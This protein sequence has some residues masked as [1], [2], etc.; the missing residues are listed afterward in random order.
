MNMKKL[1]LFI[2]I[3]LSIISVGMS[4]SSPLTTYYTYTWKYSVA[5][6][7]G[8]WQN[9]ANWTQTEGAGLLPSAT[10]VVVFQNLSSPAANVSFVITNVPNVTI[11]GLKLIKNGS[12]TLN[13][14]LKG[15]TDATVIHINGENSAND[16]NGDFV[17]NAYCSLNCNFSSGVPIVYQRVNIVLAP[18]AKG[19]FNTGAGTQGAL[20]VP[21]HY[22]T[23]DATTTANIEARRDPGNPSYYL[24]KGFLLECNATKRAELIQETANQSHIHCWVESYMPYK[25]STTGLENYHLICPPTYTDDGVGAAPSVDPIPCCLQKGD[26]LHESNDL[27][28]LG[29]PLQNLGYMVRFWDN[30]GQKWDSWLGAFPNSCDYALDFY[31]GS[32]SYSGG[33]GPNIPAGVYSYKGNGIEVYTLPTTHQAYRDGDLW[34]GPLNTAPTGVAPITFDISHVGFNLI[35]NPFPSAIRCGEPGTGNQTI[36]W[37]WNESNVEQYIYYWD[38]SNYRIWGWSSD[39]TLN[40]PAGVPVN[41]IAAGQ[42]FFVYCDAVPTTSVQFLTLNNEARKFYPNDAGLIV[43]SAEVNMLTFTLSQGENSLMDQAK[44]YFRDNGNVNYCKNLDAYKLFRGNDAVGEL[45]TRTPEGY[46]VAIKTYKASTGSFISPLYFQVGTTGT[47]K[48]TASDLSTFSTRTAIQL[49]DKK[50]NKTIDLKVNPEYSFTATN[51]DDP[52]RFDILFTDVLNGVVKNSDSPVKVYT[53]HSSIFIVNSTNNELQNANVTVCDMLGREVMQDKLF[54]AAGEVA[55][56]NANLNHGYYII[57]VR[58]SS[59]VYTQ[60]VYIE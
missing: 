56:L 37:Q 6:T 55:E 43:K 38:G 39:Y 3:M 7:G 42:G 25:T 22:I 10:S 13:V 32:L 51:G 31:V 33:V 46:D 16:A 57:S 29:A 21:A 48:L 11:D 19:M 17:I 50:E 35:G 45:Y 9:P 14:T 23:C 36:G 53:S 20:F 40:F 28:E 34:Y 59:N 12:K 2:V 60:K 47:Y 58:T 27:N 24:N 54:L 52:Y 1:L 44:I 4:Q 30:V 15:A 5:P 8:D 18:G 26:V 49:I 41:F